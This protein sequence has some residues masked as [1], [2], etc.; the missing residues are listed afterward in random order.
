MAQSEPRYRSL[1]REQILAI[2]ETLTHVMLGDFTVFARTTQPDEDFGNLC[3]MINVAINAARNARSELQE[4]NRELQQSERRFRAT[5]EQAAVGAAHV[6]PDGRWLEVNQRLCEIVG[7]TRE[8]LLERTFQDITYAPDLDTDL[9]LVREMLAGERSAYSMEKRY[10][11]K[12]GTLVWIDL[13]VSLVRDD[14]GAPQYFISVVQDIAARKLA[15]AKLARAA[16]DLEAEVLERIRADSALRESEESLA[17]TLNSIGDAVIATDIDGRITRMNPVAEDLT[18]WE[19]FE[20]RGRALS[21]VFRIVNEET[22]A[23][24]ESPAEQVLRDGLV[25][26][27]ANH[28]ILLSRNGVARPITDSGAP[29]RDAHGR[30][31]GVVLVFRDRTEERQAEQTLR[32]SEARKSAIL[33]AALDSIISMDHTGAIT[34][35]NPA[36]ERTFGYSRADAIGRSLAELLIPASL[37]QKHLDGLRRYLATGTGPILGRRI[38]IQ[39]IRAGGLEFPVELTVVPTRSDGP[40]TFTAYIRDISERQRTAQ[41]LQ[42]SEDA[43]AR[44]ARVAEQQSAHRERA[45]AALRRTEEQ[46]RQSQKMEAI[47]TLSGSIAHD[48][49]NLLSVILGYSALLIQDLQAADPIRADLEQIVRAGKRANDLTRQL[50][51]FSRQQVLEPKVINLKDSIPGMIK[52]LSRIIGEHIELA[53]LAPMTLGTVYVDPGQIEQVLLNLILN[54]RDAMPQGGKLTIET[55]DIE[56]DRAYADQHLDIE[57]GRYVMLSVSDTGAGMDRT[58]LARIFEPFFTTKEKGKGSGLGLST[59]FGIVKQSGGSIWAYSEPGEGATFKIYLPYAGGNVGL[60][61]HPLP[62]PSTVRGSETVL[63][64]E[65]DEQVRGLACTILRRHGYHVLEATTG[66]DALLI[67]E[68]YRAKIHVLLTD[69]VMPRMS[70]RQLWERLAPL[71]PTMKVIFMSGYTDDA[72]VHHGVSSAELAFVQ[73]PLL[74][75]VLLAKLRS[76]LDAKVEPTAFQI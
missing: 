38:E 67:C 72:I 63:L 42:L 50:L 7:Y 25:I 28:A 2:G 52:M 23:A 46:L 62:L 4:A 15:Q 60:S 16:E 20:A 6:A 51:A 29:I 21:D 74:P 36:A 13:T 3:A 66:G 57:P 61:T 30:L 12:D 49:N 27:I 54:A 41:A 48:F 37:R 59:V 55:A 75:A 43:G 47:G 73:K 10:V 40:P 24:V 26:G 71:R 65:D 8:E 9:E 58:T 5:F 56:L 44:A 68:Q 32:D 33:D 22:R 17:T 76:V 14:R 45:E 31:R 35:F 69:V 34:E 19:L 53:F 1:V 39:A 18:G 64:V 11:R 70:G